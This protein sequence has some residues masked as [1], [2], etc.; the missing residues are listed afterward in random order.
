ML[1]VCAPVTKKDKLEKQI[2]PETLLAQISAENGRPE[3]S[4]GI[5]GELCRSILFF[6]RRPC[7]HGQRS[8]R[9]KPPA[10][11][12]LFVRVPAFFFSP[13][14]LASDL[15]AFACVFL[16]VDN[17]QSR[18]Q[19]QFHHRV[20]QPEGF[21]FKR[22]FALSFWYAGK[23]PETICL[24]LVHPPDCSFQ[25]LD[26]LLPPLQVSRLLLVQAFSQEPP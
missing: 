9:S 8:T 10:W 12:S 1:L 19:V 22:L 24:V 11:E 5:P 23:I 3:Q 2:A 18:R 7:F 20:W 15:R 26:E 16:V 14:A 17:L 6:F 13:A 4:E 21:C 25:T